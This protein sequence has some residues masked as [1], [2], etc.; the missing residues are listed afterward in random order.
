M[1]YQMSDPQV[2]VECIACGKAI[3]VNEPRT[4]TSIKLCEDCKQAIAYASALLKERTVG[5]NDQ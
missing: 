2:C 4:D 3:P 5:R 1:K